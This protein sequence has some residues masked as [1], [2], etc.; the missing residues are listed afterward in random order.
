MAK[1]YRPVDRDQEFLLPPN[2]V[3][4]LGEDHLVWFVIEAVNR[5]DTEAF[6]RL[7][8]LGGVGRRGY[9]P[10]MVLTL[11]V[12]AM[13]H[14]V[15]SS[16]QIER[17][18]GTDV[19]FR[20]ICAQDVPDHTVLA[21]FRKNHQEAL[22][23]LLAE[24]LALAA[25]LGMVSLGTVALDGTKI[26]GNASRDANRREAHLRK[27][28]QEYLD[29]LQETD[30]AEDARCGEDAR[31]EELPPQVR[32]RTGRRERI[33][34]ALEQIKTRREQAEKASREQDQ[35]VQECEQAVAEG[36][37]GPGRYPRG[38]DRVEMARVRWR[39]ERDQADAR[40]QDWH[41]AREQGGPRRRGRGPVPPDEHHLVR[42]AWAVYQATTAAAAA[43]SNPT[44]RE[45]TGGPGAGAASAAEV[46]DDPGERFTANLTDPD[47]RLLKTRNGWIQGYNCQTATSDD[48]FIVY[49]R[50]TQDTN[51]IEQFIP[52]MDDVVATA[53]RLAERTGRED[54]KVGTLL[55][56]AGYDSRANLAAEGPDRLIADGKH[57]TI[58]RR[59]VA[60]PAT[61][62]PPND[63]SAREQMNHRLRTPEGNALYKRRSPLV[64]APNAWLKDR[65]GLRRFARRGQAAAQAEL[66]FASAVTNL[67]K[68]TTKGITATRLRTQ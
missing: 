60:D 41:A 65:R 30:E 37:K 67:L 9:H 68:I 31:G 16:R 62:D 64:E 29:K 54:L 42:Q 44:S 53:Q 3:D 8:R 47:S 7:A 48:G 17:L 24:S 14:G 18:C 33:D 39:R 1:S 61:G 32:D 49:A 6:H 19:A 5:L 46:A 55:A 20:I 34:Q 22:T 21:R 25:E 15:S 52:T 12:Y 38:T 63:A 35:R 36:T 66:A 43:A 59:A 11:F 26:A 13:A 4:W 27:L 45:S 10:E 51:D 57:H 56:D 58:D 2:M 50:A 40:Y 28:A 23:D